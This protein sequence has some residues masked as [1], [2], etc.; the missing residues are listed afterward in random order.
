MR[1]FQCSFDHFSIAQITRKWTFHDTGAGK[2]FTID[3][4]GRTASCISQA[5]ANIGEIY[6]AFDNQPTWIV[7]FAFMLQTGS[8]TNDLLGLWDGATIQISLRIDTNL[9]LRIYRGTTQL[10]IST[11]PVCTVG[12]WYHC[13]LKG[14]IDNVSGSYE[15]RINNVPVLSA[16]GVD[17]QNTANA[18]ANRVSF[19]APGASKYI[20]FDDVWM[21]DA[22][23][24]RNNSFS[25]DEKIE[26]RLANG[27]GATR[28]WLR[29]SGADDYSL[30]NEVPADDD[31]GYLY[32]DAAA[33]LFTC[34][35]QDLTSVGAIHAVQVL[36]CFRK[37][38]AGTV[39]VA[40]V[41]RPTATDYVG[42]DVS[43]PS[44][45]DYSL[46]QIY[47]VNPETGN[48]FTAAEFNA[49]EFGAKRTA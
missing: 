29:S 33:Q 12:T 32:S 44:A 39:I 1:R 16:S 18:Y 38:E 6:K 41:V 4:A 28:N 22:T 2:P 40:P 46:C 8:D 14:T 26:A 17:T 25:G 49:S 31:T 47:E 36:G 19:K 24:S 13:Q 43:A 34:P 27:N 10:G 11:N 20:K 15:A 37:D 7:G 30:I 42:N 48:P 35:F 45:Y 21:N 3:P 23:G 9:K 5:G